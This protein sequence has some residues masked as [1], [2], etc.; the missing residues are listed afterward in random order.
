[1]V[2]LV[3]FETCYKIGVTSDLK[4]RLKEFRTSREKYWMLKCYNQS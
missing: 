4:K 1:M 2:Y 3:D